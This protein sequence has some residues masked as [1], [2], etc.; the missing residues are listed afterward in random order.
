MSG[1]IEKDSGSYSSLTGLSLR[2]LPRGPHLCYSVKLI[3]E[4][5]W[6]LFC[7]YMNF[8]KESESPRVR[9]EPSIV[10]WPDWVQDDI[11]R[12]LA[13]TYIQTITIY[14]VA[15]KFPFRTFGFGV[16]ILPYFLFRSG[17]VRTV[18]FRPSRPHQSSAD[19]G[20]AW[21]AT[22]NVTHMW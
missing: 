14:R 21:K 13:R 1:S 17:N 5:N 3:Q 6:T 7:W 22:S 2:G 11:T 10:K 15:N 12:Q 16:I 9:V 19:G 8:L 4:R 18:L 20:E